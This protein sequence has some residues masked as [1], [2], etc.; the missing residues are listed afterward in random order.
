MDPDPSDFEDERQD[1]EVYDD[2]GSE[3]YVRGAR[4]LPLEEDTVLLVAPTTIGR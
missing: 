1:P 3:G 2:D 4:V